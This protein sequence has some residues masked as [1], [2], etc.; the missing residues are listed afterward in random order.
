MR[1]YLFLAVISVLA[2]LGA[3]LAP[4]RHAMRD[5][6][7]SPLKGSSAHSGAS[8]RSRAA[9][10]GAHRRAGRG[11]GCAAGARRAAGAGHGAR[12]ARRRRLRRGPAPDDEP[13]VWTRH[14]RCRRSEGVL[15]PRA[16]AGA[17]ASRRAVRVARGVCAIRRQ[18][19]GHGLPAVTPLHDLLQ[20]YAAR[21]ISRR[22]DCAR[23]A[24]G[25][26]RRRKSPAERR[27]P[28]SAKRS[29]ATSSRA[30][31]PSGNR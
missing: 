12:H 26:T 28:S 9:A 23:Y 27:S 21:T 16:R 2:G 30:R 10:L 29:R 1:V 5:N 18:Q 13:R 25:P 31:I 24:A 17:G 7:A 3:G 22:L 11:V 19:Q 4:A 6:F 14:V 15:G 8:A 20:R